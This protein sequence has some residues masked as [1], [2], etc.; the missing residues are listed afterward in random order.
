M[1]VDVSAD[2]AVIAMSDFVSAYNVA[3]MSDIL[4][5]P[6]VVAMSYIL[7]A[8]N[9]VAMSDFLSPFYLM[10][11]NMKQA[12]EPVLFFFIAHQ[13]FLFMRKQNVKSINK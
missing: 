5:A 12:F 9:V 8:C 10:P 13:P 6:D 2:N 1:F 4:S 3:A 7:S 11:A